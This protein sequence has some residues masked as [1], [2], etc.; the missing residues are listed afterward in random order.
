MYLPYS[1]T[2][3]QLVA[4]RFIFRVCVLESFSVITQISV[5]AVK[6]EYLLPQIIDM[7]NRKLLQEVWG[8][9]TW[10]ESDESPR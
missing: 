1:L 4:S 8:N 5:C 7:L 10:C 6:Q 2:L 9:T 3:C